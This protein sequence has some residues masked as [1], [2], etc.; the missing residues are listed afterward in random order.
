MF[1]NQPRVSD[2][3][4]HDAELERLAATARGQLISDLFSIFSSLNEAQSRKLHL[5]ADHLG[6]IWKDE[7]TIP[8]HWEKKPKQ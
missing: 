1:W 8:A 7:Q 2:S 6:L 4:F 5:L 3:P